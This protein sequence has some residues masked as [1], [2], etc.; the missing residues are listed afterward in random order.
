METS[1]RVPKDRIAVLIGK[2]GA[3]RKGLEKAANVSL[4]IDSTSGDVS[5][6]WDPS[7]TDPVKMM[8][9]PEIIKNSREFSEIL[10]NYRKFS[11]ILENSRKFSEIPGNFH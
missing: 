9:F 6:T 3:T 1:V 7:N 10:G 2:A 4:L 8:K 11:E 5:I